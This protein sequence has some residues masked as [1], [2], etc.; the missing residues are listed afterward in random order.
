MATAGAFDGL[1]VCLHNHPCGEN[2]VW[3]F[4]SVASIDL[5]IEWHGVSAHAGFVP[6]EGR[7]A[8]LAVEV[9]LH[10]ANLMQEQLVPQ[11]RLK[12]I[13]LDGGQAVNV[14]PGYSKVLARYRGP[15]AEN[16]REH[17]KW[18]RDIATGAALST[19]TRATATVLGGT[20]ECLENGALAEVMNGRMAHCF[21]VDWTEEDQVFARAIQKEIGKPQDGMAV[22]VLPMPCKVEVS[23]S[24]DVGD[25]S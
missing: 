18:I 23:G 12:Y 24:S 5:T 22:N 13:I 19:K 21:P 14:I 3:N 10:A 4:H 6:W 9:F 11:A 25:V 20:H 7:S 15:S 8:L 16:V 2:T 1:D 17:V